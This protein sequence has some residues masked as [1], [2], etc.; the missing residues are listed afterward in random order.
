MRA[1]LWD[2]LPIAKI[3]NVKVINLEPAPEGY[4][5]YMLKAVLNGLGDEIVGL[6]R[7]KLQ[8]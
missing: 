5:S 1:I 3:V 2:R 6:A 4:K 7:S 8:G